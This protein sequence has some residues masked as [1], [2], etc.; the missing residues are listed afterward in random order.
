MTFWSEHAVVLAAV[1][2][3]RGAPRGA[4]SSG[5]L[6]GIGTSSEALNSESLPC[7]PVDTRL[8][9][10]SDQQLFPDIA[11]MRVGYP[12]RNISPDHELVFASREGTFESQLF[13]VSDQIF[14]FDGAE[15]GH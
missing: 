7:L 2:R 15:T 13:E 9:Q 14:T 4:L 12:Q 5:A 8:F 6:T 1:R 11:S 3:S 10:Y